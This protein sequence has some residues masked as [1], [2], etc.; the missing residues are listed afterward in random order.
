VVAQRAGDVVTRRGQIHVYQPLLA[1]RKDGYWPAGELIE[2]DAFTGKWQELTPTLSNTCAV[3][4]HSDSRVQAQHGDYAWTLWLPGLSFVLQRFGA[5]HPRQPGISRERQRHRRRRA[6]QH[7]RRARGVDERRGEH[8]EHR[9][10]H[11]LERESQQLS[12][13]VRGGG[14]SWEI[15][16]QRGPAIG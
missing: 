7:R 14:V 9:G 16:R 1:R 5:A 13:T 4:P 15:E 6:V 11:W 3:F 10:G 12:A 2:S 8:T